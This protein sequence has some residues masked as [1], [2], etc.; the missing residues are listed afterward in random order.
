[1]R[2]FDPLPVDG[3]VPSGL[4]LL[5]AHV[6]SFPQDFAEGL[7]LG[8]E[9]E[10]P[11]GKNDGKVR[12]ERATASHGATSLRQLTSPLSLLSRPRYKASATLIVPT[13]TG[14][15]FGPTAPPSAASP[16]KSSCERP[17]DGY[18][19]CLTIFFLQH[20]ININAHGRDELLKLLRH[21]YE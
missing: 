18:V 9:F 5:S 2:G 14:S 10:L 8:I 1:L 6:P 21:D 4:I 19:L 16:A 13:G 3:H 15:S 7:F 11:T 17:T 20:P 12:K